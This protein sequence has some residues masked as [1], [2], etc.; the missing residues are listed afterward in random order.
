MSVKEPLSPW[1]A[2]LTRYHW[3]V[4]TICTLGWLF[5][6]M[7]QQLFALA[8]S[9]AIADLLNI[10]ET[11]PDV[12][13][14]GGYATSVTL[15]GW[16]TGGIIF[17]I[18]G[19]KLGRARTMVFTI[20]CYAIFTGL[21]GFSQ[22]VWQ[23]IA[24]RFLTGLGVGGQF[25]V[26]VSLVAETMPDRARPRA[27]G[28]LQALSAVGN[29]AAAFLAMGFG[30]LEAAGVLPHAAWRWVLGIGI[31]PAL[32]AIIVSRYLKE[33]ESWRRAVGD[34][35]GARHKAGSLRELFGTPQWRS[36]VILGMVLASAGVIGLWGIGF[37][38][39]DLNRTI[40]RKVAE[41]AAREAGQAE[42]DRQLVRM[43]IHSP[44]L[45]DRVKGSVEYR[46]LLSLDA[47]E[48]DPR[49]LFAQALRLRD[50][51]EAVSPTALLDALDKPGDHGPAQS[52]GERR[53]R[54]RYLDLDGAVPDSSA[55]PEL[56][57]Q[58]AARKKDI[59]GQVSRWGGLTSMLFNIGAFFGIYAF[60]VVTDRLGRRW[61]FMLFFLAA[62]L[63]TAT[64]FMFM[65]SKL[66]VFWMVPLMGFCQL[67]VFGGYAIYFPELFPTR[68]RST[69]VSFC[70]NI[71]R[72]VAALGPS[73]LGL[74][75]SEV[76]TPAR[77][78]AEPMRW[79]GLTMSSIFVLGIVVAF[80]APET[81][82]KP[83]PE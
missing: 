3:F 45:L 41:N 55:L 77:G 7:T 65:N 82:G 19:D 24:L 60:A 23:F 14:Y 67:S 79:A 57:E 38:S 4:L 35:S 54:A 75:T 39:I 63:S 27:L 78:F 21:C 34:Q 42:Q 37:F 6:C 16:A 26:G 44:E 49:V 73:A 52:D 62:L 5:D 64:A 20:L 61:T 2:G 70:Y 13:K 56:V 50:R 71:G 10:S 66:D 47:N 58:I 68:L 17:G 53:R 8:R 80:F 18:M 81:K 74:L 69:A 28:L 30:S 22:T 76:F 46:D 83:L 51:G 9:P 15:I 36:R 25:A 72:Y 11:A 29:I 43:V 1:H 48:N 31:A 32:L 33:P 12:A 40:F 59:N